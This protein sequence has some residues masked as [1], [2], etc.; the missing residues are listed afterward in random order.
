MKLQVL[1]GCFRRILQVCRYK[2]FKNT[3]MNY[4]GNRFM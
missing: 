4:S 3:I 1:F 2:E